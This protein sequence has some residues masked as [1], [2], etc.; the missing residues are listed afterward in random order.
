[1]FGLE[2]MG[3]MLFLSPGNQI[4]S[5]QASRNPKYMSEC[6][7]SSF[8]VWKSFCS[9]RGWFQAFLAVSCLPAEPVAFCLLRHLSWTHLQ[10]LGLWIATPQTLGLQCQTQKKRKYLSSSDSSL[11]FLIADFSIIGANAKIPFSLVLYFLRYWNLLYKDPHSFTSLWN[12]LS[13]N[14]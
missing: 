9:F 8:L 7:Q 14:S 1:M 6:A 5:L 13:C 3:R 2:G 10:Q 12:L 11:P 4:L